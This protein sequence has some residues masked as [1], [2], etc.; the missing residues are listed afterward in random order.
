M[1]YS[2]PSFILSGFGVQCLA[3]KWIFTPMKK[4]KTLL[5]FLTYIL[6]LEGLIKPVTMLYVLKT[7]NKDQ[8]TD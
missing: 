5:F 6:S 7:F 8:I 3:T 1:I 4:G 2:F